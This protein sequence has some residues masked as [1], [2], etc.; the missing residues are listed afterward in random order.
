MFLIC[1]PMPEEEVDRFLVDLDGG[2]IQV[3]AERADGMCR[4]H[5]DVSDVS[6]GDHTAKVAACNEWGDGEFSDPFVFTKAFPSKV[7]GVGLEL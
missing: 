6:L 4:L 7:S 2:L 3:D 5:Y 1:D